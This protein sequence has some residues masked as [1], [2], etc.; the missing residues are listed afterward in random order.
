MGNEVSTKEEE[1]QKTESAVQIFADL[2]VLLIEE[3]NKTDKD[4]DSTKELL[5][6]IEN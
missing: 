1:K 4:A 5:N 3:N 2:L 6:N